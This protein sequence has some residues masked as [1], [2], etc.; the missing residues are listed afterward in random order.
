[1]PIH[2]LRW[3]KQ[4]DGK[5]ILEVQ[6]MTPKGP[7]MWFKVPVTQA[8]DGDYPEPE[9]SA[10][11]IRIS[12]T[13]LRT[14]IHDYTQHRAGIAAGVARDTMVWKSEFGPTIRVDLETRPQT[15]E[16][17]GYRLDWPKP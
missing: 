2:D 7:G 14:I 9:K 4:D 5:L 11:V 3:V 13:T 1:M 6:D 16:S 8:K 10:E 12:E 17:L 15:Q